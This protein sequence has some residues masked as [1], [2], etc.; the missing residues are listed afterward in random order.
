VV[1]DFPQR[2]Q[3]QVVNDKVRITVEVV[4]QFKY[5]DV[6]ETTH[7][8]EFAYRMNIYGIE[9][10]ASHNF[11]R[12]KLMRKWHPFDLHPGEWEF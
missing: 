7:T 2:W 4:G 1:C 3:N 12:L 10:N 8:Q 6:F 9:R 5:R 11:V